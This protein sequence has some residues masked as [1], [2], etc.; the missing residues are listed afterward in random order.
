MIGTALLAPLAAMIIQMAIS[1]SREYDADRIG[2]EISGQPLALA[3]ALAKIAGGVHQIPNPR[4]SAIRRPRRCSSSI[5]SP[6][7]AWTTSS[8]PIRRPRTGSRRSRRWPGAR[9]ADLRRAASAPAALRP[10]GRRDRAAAR[11]GAR[12][13]APRGPRGRGSGPP[14]RLD[15]GR[16]EVLKR[17]APLDDV[18]D[19][20]PRGGSRPARRGAGASDRG[21]DLRRFGT[22]RH[23]LRERVDKGP[24][25]DRRAV[26]LLATGAAQVLFL[27][28]PDHAAVDTAVRIARA[29]RSP[30]PP[31]A[32]SS[33]RSSPGGAGA[34]RILP[35]R[36]PWRD[37]PE[38]LAR[39]WI[40][41]LR[42]ETGRA[43]AAAHRA[44]PPSI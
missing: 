18:L 7:T 15:G 17:P 3:S 16:R 11:L 4:R 6:A 9:R 13:V 43:I 5:R 12:P 22:I 38:W 14:A 40:V 20:P 30:P 37:T 31:R 23:A 27:D 28:V 10:L 2:A 26:A 35:R 1:R 24:P 39:R 19:E 32:G 21:R 8:R 41:R 44:R 42:D 34:G 25:K 33:T 36:R 29:D